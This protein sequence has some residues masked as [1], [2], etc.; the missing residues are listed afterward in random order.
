MRIVFLTIINR[1]LAEKQLYSNE[2]CWTLDGRIL[3]DRYS[4][5]QHV[6][7]L[8]LQLV[9]YIFQQFPLEYECL[10]DADKFFEA[11]TIIE[12]ARGDTIPSEDIDP[13]IGE[14]GCDNLVPPPPTTRNRINAGSWKHAPDGAIYDTYA[15]DIVDDIPEGSQNAAVKRRQ[16]MFEWM[17]HVENRSRFIPSQHDV[18]FEKERERIKEGQLGFRGAKS[19]TTKT[20][21]K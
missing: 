14:A 2:A 20:T 3:A 4:H 12:D 6:S 18:D 16:Q 10:I 13:M 11:C 21:G 9:S 19:K 15:Q 1:G 8:T 5:F 17:D 7:R